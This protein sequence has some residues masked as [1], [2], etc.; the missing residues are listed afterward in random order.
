MKNSFLR[1]SAVVGALACSLSAH[2]WIIT[3]VGTYDTGTGL[4]TGTTLEYSSLPQL[5]TTFSYDVSIGFDIILLSVANGGSS[6][7]LTGVGELSPGSQTLS[8]VGTWT[9]TH[10]ALPI[11]DFGTYSDSIDDVGNFEFTIVG[12][13]AVPEPGT[14]AVFGL[15]LVGLIRRSVR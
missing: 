7:T 5:N 1:L 14:Y 6:L 8:T 15:G 4:L 11:M 3:V 12:Q 10:V 2:A 13:S 9:G